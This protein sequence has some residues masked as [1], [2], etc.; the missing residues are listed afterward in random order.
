VNWRVLIQTVYI[1]SHQYYFQVLDVAI[2]SNTVPIYD[3][4]CRRVMNDFIHSCLH[5]DSNFVKSIVLNGIS[6]GM[7]LIYDRTKCPPLLSAH[8][9]LSIGCIGIIKLSFVIC[10]NR[11]DTQMVAK[12]NVYTFKVLMIR[13]GLLEFSSDLFKYSELDAFVKSL[14]N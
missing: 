11:M 3:E 13:D 7:T 2:V 6:A 10:N 8:F 9:H 12:P 1:L 4:L 14:A 5:C